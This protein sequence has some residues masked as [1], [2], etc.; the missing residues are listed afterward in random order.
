LKTSEVAGAASDAK[1]I[2]CGMVTQYP[3]TLDLM[4]EL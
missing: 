1:H 3:K 4:V 2:F